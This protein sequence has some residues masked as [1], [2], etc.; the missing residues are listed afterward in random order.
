MAILF[1]RV[2]PAPLS[3]NV[4]PDYHEF[5][6]PGEIYTFILA[7]T[8]SGTETLTFNLVEKSPYDFS[9]V[10]NPPSYELPLSIDGGTTREFTIEYFGTLEFDGVSAFIQITGSGGN[11][12]SLGISGQNTG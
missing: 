2:I 11:T 10:N 7:A 9:I 12:Y 3:F 8:G 6:Y 5:T 1:K 4:Y